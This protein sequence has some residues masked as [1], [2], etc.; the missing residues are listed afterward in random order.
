[1]HP[2]EIQAALRLNGFSQV[3]I[4]RELDIKPN[5]VSMVINGRSRSEKIEKRIAEATRLPL[6][7]LW[8]RWH[9]RVGEQKAGYGTGPLSV[10][11]YLLIQGF[12]ELT[13]KQQSEVAMFVH[14]IGA[15]DEVREKMKPGVHISN[16]KGGRVAG[17]DFIQ[18]GGVVR[19]KK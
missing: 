11:E 7:K 9:G 18:G 5:T 12:R 16:V 10:D 1:M 2:A 13:P 4:A 19:K 3:D 15:R 6:A 14:M 17:R 8:P